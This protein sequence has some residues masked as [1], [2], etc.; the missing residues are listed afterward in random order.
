MKLH[1]DAWQSVGFHTMETS[2]YALDGSRGPERFKLCRIVLSILHLHQICHAPTK[3]V[4]PPPPPNGWNL[5][6]ISHQTCHTP[7]QNMSCQHQTCHT[8]PQNLSHISTK[9]VIPT[10]NLSYISTNECKDGPLKI[11]M[12]TWH[13]YHH[14]I[15]LLLTYQTCHTNTKPVTYLHQTC[16]A[17]TKPVTYL[18]KACHTS[19]PNLSPPPNMSHTSTKPVT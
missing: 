13:G 12:Q 17:N 10:P 8:S 11:T 19:P 18:H 3:P 1:K 16:H 6:H 7:P 5:S 14:E 15:K 9:P 2:R 4:K